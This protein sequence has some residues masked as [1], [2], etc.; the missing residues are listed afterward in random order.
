LNAQQRVGWQPT[1]F[2]SD[3]AEAERAFALAEQLGSINAAAAQ[4]AW[5][6]L[7]KAFTRHGLGMPA[8]NPEAVRQRAMAATR[9]PSGRPASPALDPVFVALNP[10][11]LPARDRPALASTILAERSTGLVLAARDYSWANW[12]ATTCQPRLAPPLTCMVNPRPTV[13]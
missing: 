5:P 12:I 11:A 4:L 10:S 1:R 9:P 8:Q 7:R 6:S 13:V 2:L 3:Q